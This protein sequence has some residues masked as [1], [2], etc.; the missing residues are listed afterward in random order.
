MTLK[1]DERIYEG[2]PF[3][4]FTAEAA[5]RYVGQQGYFAEK[6]HAYQNLDE[7]R[8]GTLARVDDDEV[9]FKTDRFFYQFFLPAEFVRP[10]EK[11]KWRPFTL[12]EFL[13]KFPLM[14]QLTYRE[15][16]NSN[17]YTVCVI[18]HGCSRNGAMRVNLG[19]FFYE[20]DNLFNCYEL[21]DK[22]GNW[23]PF[24]VEDK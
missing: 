23:T 13:A 15:K 12:D 14:S 1:L 24:G 11:K 20:L 8:F 10:A 9:P 18:G 2:L 3:T 6:I 16:K 5:K 4:C 22:D 7:T 19:G 17:C 21:K